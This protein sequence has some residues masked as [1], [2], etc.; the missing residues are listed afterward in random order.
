MG[1]I[2]A[3]L[4]ILVFSGAVFCADAYEM[5]TITS[6]NEVHTSK[7]KFNEV[8]E[9]KTIRSL[10]LKDSFQAMIYYASVE[11]IDPKRFMFW[12]DNADWDRI[13]PHIGHNDFVKIKNIATFMATHSDLIEDAKAGNADSALMLSNLYKE[14]KNGT[15][16]PEAIYWLKVSAEGGHSEALLTY[17]IH[18]ITQN[19]VIEA[20]PYVRASAKKGFKP[21]VKAFDGLKRSIVAQDPVLADKVFK[22]FGK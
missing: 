15:F 12:Y 11:N 2:S 14:R 22:H 6:V 16:N 17:G 13:K 4:A 9:L 3:R 10:G 18:L 20:Y 1:P 8:E 19:K 7:H 21:A 5:R